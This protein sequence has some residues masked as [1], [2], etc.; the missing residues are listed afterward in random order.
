MFDAFLLVRRTLPLQFNELE[1]NLL[2]IK[3][4]RMIFIVE[5]YS[6]IDAYSCIRTLQSKCS[7]VRFPLN[8]SIVL[9]Q[10]KTNILII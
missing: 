10:M 6:L 1:G 2:T 3:S 4:P 7:F 5:L 9:V 8:K